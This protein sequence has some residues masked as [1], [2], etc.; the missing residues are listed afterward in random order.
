LAI[1]LGG[2]TIDQALETAMSAASLVVRGLGSRGQ[3]RI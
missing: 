1:R 2:G 3:S